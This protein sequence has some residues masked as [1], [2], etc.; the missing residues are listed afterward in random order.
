MH[1]SLTTLT[2]NT[3]THKSVYVCAYMLKTCNG[4][5]GQPCGQTNTNIHME[6]M[7]VGSGAVCALIKIL[8]YFQAQNGI[9]LPLRYIYFHG[10]HFSKLSLLFF[11]YCA[12]V[13]IINTHFCAVILFRFYFVLF[14]WFWFLYFWCYQLTMPT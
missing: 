9:M 10:I 11:F 1:N 3:G 13:C 14:I 2:Q 5:N 7:T 4:L 6:S 12:T 8:A